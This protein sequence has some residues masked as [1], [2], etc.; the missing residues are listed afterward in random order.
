MSSSPKQ[1]LIITDKL[2]VAET[3]QPLENWFTALDKVGAKDLSHAD[4]FEKT[5]QIPGLDKL[6]EWNRNLLTTSYEWSRGLK[7]R[8]EKKDGFEISVSKTIQ[9]DVH[10]LYQHWSEK[11]LRK[12]WLHEEVAIGTVR[13][14]KS[15]RMKWLDGHSRLSVEL[16]EKAAN[17]TQVVVQHLKISSSPQAEELK[18][19][20]QQKLDE[21]KEV[22]ENNL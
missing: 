22:L 6:N 7:E 17:K 14:K 10:N 2:V 4:I 12:R 16:Y 5:G 3:G 8:G 20:W 11:N 15:L 1:R 18:I 19:F 9:T 13:E 21:L